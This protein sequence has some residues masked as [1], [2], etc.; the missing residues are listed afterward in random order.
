MRAALPLLPLLLVALSAGCTSPPP[1]PPLAHHG[2]GALTQP[3]TSMRDLVDWVRDKTDSCDDAR[4]APRTEFAA[5][6]GPQLAELYE[7]YVA[8]WTTCSVSE[9]YPR[10]GLIL[11]K[12][13]P[14]F[15][16]SWR[17]AMAAGKVSD[18]PSLS[19]GNGFAV[20]PAFLGVSELGLY[21]LRCQY[22]DPRVH[23]VP[24]DVEGCVFAN[25][26]HQHG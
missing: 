8:E 4:T 19:F 15:Q 23:Q 25:P 26:E 9:S 1:P 3:M 20:S 11:F 16:T 7:P 6:V 24:A 10:V 5:F 14:A 2:A 12:E 22:D 21:Y 17:D 18:G 13:L